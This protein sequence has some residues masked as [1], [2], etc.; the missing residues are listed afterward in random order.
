MA[1]WD[2]ILANSADLSEIDVIGTANSRQIQTQMNRGGAL[3]FTMNTFDDVAKYVKKAKTCVKAKRNDSYVWTGPVWTIAGDLAQRT[4]QIG[5]VGWQEILARRLLNPG[6]DS[7]QPYN[8]LDQGLIAMNLLG[9]ANAQGL[10]LPGA[11]SSTFITPGFVQGSGST[12]LR[13][14]SYKIWD[15]IGNEIQALSDIEN[16]FDYEVHPITRELNIYYPRIGI[17]R[18]DIH[19]GFQAGPWNLEDV[20]VQEDAS[21]YCNRFAAL[22]KL[23]GQYQMVEDVMSMGDIGLFEDTASISDVSDDSV[24]MAFAGSEIAFRLNPVTYALVPLQQSALEDDEDAV[25]IPRLF[26]DFNTGDTF[27]F[28]TNEGPYIF[29]KQAAR[30]F[31][32]SM[33]IDDNDNEKL[34]T[35]TTI[36]TG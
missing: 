5:C 17:D 28:S 9:K 20:Q 12:G 8:A 34:D 3:S 18:P 33:T 32:A 1:N 26:E 25:E 31:G 22:G 7:D 30:C 24:L 21:R 14:H 4:M 23:T 15:N 10:I 35:I 6:Q 36:L 16:G 29:D 13:T 27:R 19:F 11:A 2:F